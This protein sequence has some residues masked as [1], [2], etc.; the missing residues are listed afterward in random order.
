MPGGSGAGDGGGDAPGGGGGDGGGGHEKLI[1]TK[2]GKE[3][4]R[5]GKGG[6]P[7]DARSLRVTLLELTA[8]GAGG[9]SVVLAAAGIAS[10]SPCNCTSAGGMG[11]CC[12]IFLTQGTT[13]P[14]RSPY[15]LYR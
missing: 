5:D 3:K 6:I 10:A 8:G 12:L 7:K 15:T 13:C 1:G 9:R 14:H 11:E 2:G 4:V